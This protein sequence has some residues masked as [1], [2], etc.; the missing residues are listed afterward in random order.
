MSQ[1]HKAELLKKLSLDKG[2]IR[3]TEKPSIS[4]ATLIALALIALVLVLLSASVVGLLSLNDRSAAQQSG[5]VVTKS[6]HEMH[7]PLTKSEQD[8][9]K[10]AES[11]LK[12]LN[13]SGFVTARQRATISAEIMGRIESVLVEEGATVQQGQVLA[14]IDDT[15]ARVDW[16][17]AEA[18]VEANQQRLNS[19]K[20]ERDEAKRIRDRLRSLD[21]KQFTSAAELSRAESMLASQESQ[22]KALQAELKVSVFSLERQKELLDKHTLRAPFSGVVTAKN[23]QLGEIIS[24]SSA[25][26]GFTRTGICTIVDM[27]S[28]EIEVDVNEAYIGRVKINQHVVAHLDAYPGWD[29]P[30]KVLAV[31]PAADRAKATVRVRIGLLVQDRKILPDMGVKVTFYE[32]KVEGEKNG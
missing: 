32:N 28:L 18:R 23:A 19:L 7:D 11:A 16:Q 27:E 29:I 17:L 31:I 9:V 4:R 6:E 21:L 15:L 8:L 13:A 1:E 22:I 20:A 5:S 14:K 26:G 24:P 12:I 2:H 25:G 3:A 30:A 10:E